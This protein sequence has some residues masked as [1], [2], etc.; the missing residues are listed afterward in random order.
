MR[1]QTET[2]LNP[3][4][5]HSLRAYAR[6]C[7]YEAGQTVVQRG[8]PGEAFYVVISGELEVQLRDQDCTLILTRLAEGATFGEMSLLTGDPVSADVITLGPTRVLKFSEDNFQKAL[9]ESAALRNH[10]LARLSNNLRQTSSEAWNLFQHLEALNALLPQQMDE[11]PIIAESNVMTRVHRRLEALGQVRQPLLITGEPGA[12]KLFAAKKIHEA[13]GQTDSPLIVVDC[14]KLPHETASK[15]LFGAQEEYEFSSRSTK[16]GTSGLGVQGAL[17]LADKGRLV[18]RHIDALQCSEQEF[19]RKYLEAQG[20]MEDIY[21]DTQVIATT[22]EDLTACVEQD[23][24]GA[25]L[26]ERFSANVLEMPTLRKRRA[27]ILPLAKL[28]LIQHDEQQSKVDASNQK[29][30]H[31]FAQ[32]AEHALLSATYRHRNAEELREAVELAVLFADGPEVDAEY[33]FTGPKDKGHPIEYDLGQNRLVRWLCRKV[34]LRLLQ[35]LVLV[36]FVGIT[37]CC[38]AASSTV[39]GRTAN[40]LVWAVWWPVLMILFLCVGRL[41]CTVCPI[42][43]TGRLIRRLGSFQWAPPNWMKTYTPWL[44][45][46]GFLAIIWSE[47]VFHMTEHPVA[48]GCLLLSLIGLA[49]LFCLLFQREVW[50]RYV[51]PLGSLGASYSAASPVSVHANAG[52]CASQCTTHECFKGSATENGCPM[53]HHPLYVRDAHFCKLCFTCLRSCPHQSARIYLRPPLQDLWR[54]EDFSTTLVPFALVVFNLTIMLLAA[55]RFS[56][57]TGALG[58][59]VLSIIATGLAAVMTCTLS[60]WF[61]VER[62]PAIVSRIMFG[63]LILGWGPFMAVHLANIPQLDSVWVYAS[64]GSIWNRVCGAT[65]LSV[66]TLLQHLVILFSALVAGIVFWRIRSRYAD[67]QE[68]RSLWSWNLLSGIG[69]LYILTALALTL[70]RGALF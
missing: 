24:L 62:D 55:Q 25:E 56:W 44:M 46:L 32:G 65:G 28:F 64:S 47:Q 66:L 49:V 63:L 42:S 27:D 7:S 4:A 14:R 23:R 58:F 10:V 22:R 45:A 8:E 15:I 57:V 2:C 39:L 50:C 21:P 18:L 38:L 59:T 12:G 33:I 13:A 54:M 16:D 48:T 60:R 17:H 1:G 41:W 51:C 37:I 34:N 3:E 20:R 31:H 19:L 35:F 29:L 30:V 69:I 11:G 43:F 70:P 40:A 67:P 36:F 68:R 6:E 5:I 52:V 26:G 9:S 53:F 61:P